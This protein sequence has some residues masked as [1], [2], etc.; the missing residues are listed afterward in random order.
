MIS[1]YFLCCSD[2]K[3]EE[4]QAGDNESP[5]CQLLRHQSPLCFQLRSDNIL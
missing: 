5:V 3:T 2:T 1:D 4:L